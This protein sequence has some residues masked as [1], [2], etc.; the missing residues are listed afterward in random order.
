MALLSG[1]TSIPTSQIVNIN[2][3]CF[4]FA[5]AGEGK[6]ISFGFSKSIKKPVLQNAA[7]QEKAKVD[8]I[9]CVD[10]KSIKIIGYVI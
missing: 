7:P 2:L 8:Y 3:C 6:K 4:A 1:I 10:D 9:E 5:M